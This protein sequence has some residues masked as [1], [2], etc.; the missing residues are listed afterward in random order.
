M[1]HKP[2]RQMVKTI[3]SSD[4]EEK[5]QVKSMIPSARL[6]MNGSRRF[7]VKDNPNPAKILPYLR[8]SA[9][10]YTSEAAWKNALERLTA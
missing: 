1:I 2:V 5:D 6:M 8:I 10:F 9:E 7:I 4:S 3:A